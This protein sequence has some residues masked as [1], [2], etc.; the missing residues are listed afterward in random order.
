MNNFRSHET[1]K[2][3]ELKEFVR[4]FYAL[5]AYYE[6]DKQA[7]ESAERIYKTKHGRRKYRSYNSF[8]VMRDRNTTDQQKFEK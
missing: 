1:K 8:R 7:Y 2:H 6:T 3:R 5:H 4:L